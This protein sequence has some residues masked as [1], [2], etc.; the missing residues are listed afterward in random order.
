MYYLQIDKKLKLDFCEGW[1]ISYS[2]A[3]YSNYSQI[4]YRGLCPSVYVECGNS[5]EWR[6]LKKIYGNIHSTGKLR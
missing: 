2:P 6:N 4:R 5:I 1:I 3:V